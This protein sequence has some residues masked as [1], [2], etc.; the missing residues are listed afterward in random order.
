MRSDALPSDLLLL[1]KPEQVRRYALAKGWR[2]VSGVNGDIALFNHP[3]E[4]WNQLIVPMDER[5]IDYPKRV[6]DLVEILA[7]SES[8]TSAEVLNDLLAGDAD[9]IRYRRA[10]TAAARGTLPLG[11]ALR[12]LDG[13]Y[14]SLLASACSVVKPAA[15]HPRM[16]YGGAQQ[17]MRAC[18]FGQT[19]QQSFTITIACPLRAVEADQNVLAGAEPFARSAVALLVRS[20]GRIVRAIES[21]EVPGAWADSP[22]EPPLSSNLCEALLEM[23]PGDDDSALTLSVA[24]AAVLPG[25]KDIA[26]SVRIKNSYFPLIEDVYKELR[27]AEPTVQSLFVGYVDTLSGQPGPDGRVQ[28]ETT[29]SVVYEEEMRKARV[30]LNAD[31]YQVAIDAHRTAGTVK[32]KGVFHPGRRIH[33]I[34]GVN[35]FARLQ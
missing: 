28:G 26:P 11:E 20:V 6:R 8:R 1:V 3:H 34:S 19:E 4:Q 12:L 13:A 29:L 32:F 16:S 5:S 2:R 10:S 18:Q 35:E 15:Y 14:K 30:D 17:L 31:D 7:E 22:G 9:L 23:Q 33:R 21:D 24:W 27:R 25:P